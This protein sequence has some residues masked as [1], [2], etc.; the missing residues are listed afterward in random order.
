M[1]A[2]VREVQVGGAEGN[3]VVVAAGLGAGDRVVTA[4]VHVLSPGQKVR[5]Y[6][7][8]EAPIASLAAASASGR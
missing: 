1:T 3:D 8:P 6:D 5:L 7:D 4:G 2:T